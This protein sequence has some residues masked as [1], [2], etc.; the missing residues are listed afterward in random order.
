MSDL[1][2]KLKPSR[3]KRE[4]LP[5]IIISIIT[6]SSLVYFSYQDS[7]GSITHSPDVPIINIEVSNDITNSS[8]QCFIK[9]SPVSY[10]FIGSN[11]ANRFLG[12]NIRKRNSDGGLSFELFQPENL[13]QIRTDDD[14]LLLPPGKYL[15]SLRTKMAFDVYNMLK[16]NDHNYMLPHSKLVEV[17]INGIYQNLYLLSE[18]IDRKLMNLD[19]EN[20]MIFKI[21]NWDGDFFTIY[22]PTST[23]WEQLHPDIGDFSQIP[24]NLTQ[25]I[26]NTSEEDFFNEQHGIFTIFEKSE[27]IDNLLFGLLTGHEIIEGSS[28]YLIYN[29]KNP[30]EFFFLPWNFAQSWGFSKDGSIPDDIWL[31]ESN[32]EIVS[33]CWSKLYHRLLFPINPSINDEFVSEIKSRWS[34]VRST[35]WE[36]YIINDYFNDLYSKILDTLLRTTIDN[37]DAIKNAIKSWYFTRLNLLD[38]MFS[39]QGN[40]FNDN[41]KSP[42]REDDEIFGFSSPAARRHY[43]KSSLLFSRQKIHE[44]N[45][46][47]QGDYL[48]DMIYRKGDYARSNE[49]LFMRADVS[50]DDYSMDNTGIRIRANYNRNYPKDSFKLK[51]S[52]TEFYLRKEDFTEIYE[53]IPENEN[54]RFLG[55]RRLNLRAAPIDFSIMNE[56]AGYELFNILGYP[57]PRVSWAKL[58][59]TETDEIGNIIK[60][61]YKGLYLLTEDI[62]KT[63]LN[64]NFKNPEGNLYK[65]TDIPANLEY[66]EDLKTFLTYDGRRIYELRTNEIQDDYSDLEEL[67]YAINF[68][69]SNIQNVVNMT[70]LAKYFAVS[71]FIGN[72]D[73]YVFLPHNYFLYSDPNYGFVFLPWDIE[74]SF[75][76]GTSSSIIGFVNPYSPNFTI[77]PLLSGYNGYFDWISVWAQIDP[78]NRPLWDNLIIDSDFTDP[79]LNSHG[80]IVNNMNDLVEQIEQWFDFIEPTVILPFQY[81]D[82]YPNPIGG[83][84][85]NIEPGWFY[86]EKTRVLTFLEG[87]TQY[88][89]SQLP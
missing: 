86:Y 32:N 12:A 8:Q 2:E 48:Y 46:V 54:R 45:V 64:Y 56:V 34:Y 14:W 4:L 74:M 27:I 66:K 49:R 29:Q 1:L 25:F 6:I 44:V 78:N 70:L 89:I 42:F 16:E 68:N 53:Y 65:T 13:F 47:I 81:T 77:A 11:W 72:W 18:R 9:V 60:K 41:F 26:Q 58:Y 69:W 75:N 7:S 61:E 3:L 30:S 23:P 67:I 59:I 33:V 71:N 22:N 87:R 5:F 76:M 38:N 21:T 79:Y 39:K 52:E 57:S 80:K 10:E 82:P 36:T 63:F 50:I 62:D 40:I 83:W 51:F 35:V 24:I 73:D 31:N 43:F 88:V 55:L 28:Y 84:I 85:L 19:Q 37:V 20:D 15:D 17:H